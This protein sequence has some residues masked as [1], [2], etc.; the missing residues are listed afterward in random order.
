MSSRLFLVVAVVVCLLACSLFGQVPDPSGHWEG[1]IHAA[2]MEDVIEV[3]LT[4]SLKGELTRTFGNAVQNV[5]GFPLSNAAAT[6]A[7]VTTDI[8]PNRSAMP[9]G[10]P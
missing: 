4:R 8:T 1:E 7:T 6:G 5:R 3:D 9:C 2:R 10:T